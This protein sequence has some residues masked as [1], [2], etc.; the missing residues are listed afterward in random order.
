MKLIPL[1]ALMA[2]TALA[3][4]AQAGVTVT[5]ENPGV[6]N[7]TATLGGPSGVETFNELSPGV[8]NFTTDYG[9]GG[10][11]TGSYSNVVVRSA[12]AFGGAGGTNFAGADFNHTIT[13]SLTNTEDA[14][15]VKYFGFWLSAL[16]AGNL[17]TLS[18]NGTQIFSF[19]PT[20]VLNAVGSNPAYFGN[21]DDGHADGGEPFVFVNFFSTTAFNGITFSESIDGN[22][23]E[24]DNHTVAESFRTVTGNPLPGVP[25]PATWAMMLLGFGGAGALLRQQRR[26]A[27]FA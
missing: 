7:T 8:Q 25:E 18:E 15:G 17:L 21:P 20:T 19:D 13:L 23:Y 22:G 2:A 10:V 9:T 1:A 11:I 12:D 6:E 4:A 27:A 14:G 26:R 24:S 16:D 3:G 5:Y